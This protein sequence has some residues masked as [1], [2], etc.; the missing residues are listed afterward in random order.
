MGILDDRVIVITGG[1]GGIGS[2]AASV[3]AREDARVVVSDLDEERGAAIASSIESDGGRASFVAADVSKRESVKAMVEHAVSTFGRLDG[4]FNAAGVT[5]PL[6]PM[7]GYPDEWFDRVLD[8][9][10]RGIWYCLQE[11]IPAIIEAGGGSIVNVSSA[12]GTVAAPGMPAYVASKHAV[13]GMTQSAALENASQGVRINALLLGVIDTEMPKKLTENNPGVM[14][15]FRSAMPLG[16]LGT[17]GEVAEAGAWLLSSRASFV[18]G[19]G[20]AVDGGA[21]SQ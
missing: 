19:H 21:L 12:L 4:A 11:Q 17:P 3:F 6:Q 8:V 5:G 18:T 2:V 16:R 20:M 7:V 15:A 13:M 9:N 10:L 14:E 1:A